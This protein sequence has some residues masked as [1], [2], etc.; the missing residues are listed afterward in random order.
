VTQEV[1]KIQDKLLLKPFFSEDI[2]DAVFQLSEPG[3]QSSSKVTSQ[4]IEDRTVRTEIHKTIKRIFHGKLETSTGDGGEITFGLSNSSTRGYNQNGR[5]SQK[6]GKAEKRADGDYLHF[7]LYKENRDTMEVI[8]LIARLLN[9]NQKVLQFAGTKDR[10][11]VTTQQVSAYRGSADR[12]AGLNKLLHNAKVGN[13]RYKTN[14]LH[15]GDLRG[16]EFHITLRDCDFPSIANDEE[17]VS[18]ATLLISK[19]AQDFK[20]TGF[21]NYYGLQRFGSFDVGTQEVGL[22]MLKGDFQGAVDLILHYDPALLEKGDDVA[23]TPAENQAPMSD[24]DVTRAKA[25]HAFKTTGDQDVMNQLPRKFAAESAIIRHLSRS[26]LSK[27]YLGALHQIPRNLRLMYVHAYQSMVWNH[28]A[29]ERWRRWGTTVVD[30]D[31]VLIPKASVQKSALTGKNGEQEDSDVNGDLDLSDPFQRARPITKEEIEN[32][33]FSIHDVVLPTPGFDIIYPGNAIGEYYK[34]FMA[35]PKGGGIDP[36]DMRRK[37]RD[38][39]LS[40]SYRQFL[41]RIDGDIDVAIHEYQDET[42]QLVSTDLNRLNLE[43][44]AYGKESVDESVLVEASNISVQPPKLA[45]V[46]K[47][48]LLSSQYATMALREISKGGILAFEPT[49]KTRGR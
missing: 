13:F 8:N 48:R 30:G 29:S 36:T 45:I 46:M 33:V 12:I 21:I 6:K 14:D 25:I 39:S 40:G 44:S 47:F 4:P 16:N 37:W 5:K 7:T 15:L 28:V 43:F 1:Q 35:G 49:F 42:Q 34:S 26:N 17:T 41:A 3:S 9:M 2:I 32:N 18:Q 38:I 10:R 20:E 23:V 24:F 31:L 22:Q 11:A 27:D 19:A